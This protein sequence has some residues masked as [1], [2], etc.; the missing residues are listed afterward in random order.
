[1]VDAA[2]G[3]VNRR[4][5]GSSVFNE[6]GNIASAIMEPDGG[7][8]GAKHVAADFM[9]VIVERTESVGDQSGSCGLDPEELALPVGRAAV[10]EVRENVGDVSDV[11]ARSVERERVLAAVGGTVVDPWAQE[12]S[13]LVEKTHPVPLS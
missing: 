7:E 2:P 8:V 1:V 13:A 4:G 10:L 3:F 11:P 6:R 12:E 5:P 9:V